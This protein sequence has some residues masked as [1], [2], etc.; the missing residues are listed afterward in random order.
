M[1]GV[2]YFPE[3]PK[4]RVLA[5]EEA[6]C[7]VTCCGESVRPVIV[8]ALHTGMRRGELL[9]LKWEDVSF[10]HRFIRITRSKNN[11]S[12]KVPMNS[13]VYAELKRLRKVRGEY[14]FT[15]LR[16]PERLRCVRSAFLRACKKA[17]IEALRFHDLRHTFAT[18]LVMSGV[19]LVTVKELLGHSDISMTVRY[20]HP[21]DS[22]K[23]EAVETLVQVKKPLVDKRKQE[24][25]SH[26][27]VTIP[28]SDQDEGFVSH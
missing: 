15:K 28:E 6:Q 4:E 3:T 18:N 16:S 8:L 1:K 21:S 14:V 24:L 7:L 19:D 17:G 10:T 12:R 25:Y 27:L 20:S 5:V 2:P 9:E 23:M 26:N 13:V 22:R 11:R